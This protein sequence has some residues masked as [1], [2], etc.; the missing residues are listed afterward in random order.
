MVE[1]WPCDAEAYGGSNCFDM[2][3][4]LLVYWAL[5]E[6]LQSYTRIEAEWAFDTDWSLG[7]CTKRYCKRTADKR[8]FAAYSLDCSFD[9]C[10]H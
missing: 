2:A 7:C 1:L 9:C 5:R 6:H 8:K 3:L 10:W 4:L